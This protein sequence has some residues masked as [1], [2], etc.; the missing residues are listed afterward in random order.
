MQDRG[1]FKDGSCEATQYKLRVNY[2]DIFDLLENIPLVKFVRNYIRDRP[3]FIFQILSGENIDDV[4]SRFFTAFCANSH[5]VYEIKS[6]FYSLR[7]FVK[8]CFTTR[9]RKLI[10][11]GRPV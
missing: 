7:L 11:L 3:G 4:I 10:S 5:F 6:T 9:K 1:K 2:I 8:Y